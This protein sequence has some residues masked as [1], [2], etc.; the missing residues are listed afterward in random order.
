M[1][2]FRDSGSI[3]SVFELV[4]SILGGSY[5]ELR[6]AGTDL[7]NYVSINNIG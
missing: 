1:F 3:D 5:W 4:L 6:I 7:D 2:G